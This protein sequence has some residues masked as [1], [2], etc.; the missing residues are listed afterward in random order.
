MDCLSQNS[1]LPFLNDATLIGLFLRDKDC[2]CSGRLEEED[3]EDMM[4]VAEL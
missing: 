1:H 3:W 4:A 2:S